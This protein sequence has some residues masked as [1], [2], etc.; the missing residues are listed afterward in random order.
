MKQT[1]LITGC[2]SGIGQHLAGALLLRGHR[3]LATDINEDGLRAGAAQRGWGQQNLRLQRLDVRDP[4]AW[5]EAVDRC[6]S[7]LGGLDVLLNVA[8]Y[9]HPGY[10]LDQSPVEADRHFDINTKGVVLGTQTAAREMVRRRGGHIINMSSLAGLAPVP[11]LSLYSASK[12]AVRGYSLAAAMELAPRGVAVTVI[13]P[14]AVS[15]PML[16][17]QVGYAEAA[18]T[19]AGGKAL[20]LADIEAAVDEALEKR[21]LEIV[22]AG[23]LG[24]GM[25][26][27][28]AGFL[29]GSAARLSPLLIRRGLTR[30]A[31]VRREAPEDAPGD[32]P[33]KAPSPSK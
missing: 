30:Q 32:G 17:R 11:G 22:L 18:L 26:A 16:E 8:G 29:P 13:C 9:L 23:A 1:F 14:D 3:V 5:Q 12:F 25:M 15:T 20:T 6:V 33:A 7:E 2:A 21:P 4:A 10:V 31:Q 19:F 24:R 27:R 28:L